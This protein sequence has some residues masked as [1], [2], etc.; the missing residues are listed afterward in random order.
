MHQ[1]AAV[2]LASFFA[3][4]SH[5]SRDQQ[6]PHTS[7]APTTFCHLFSHSHSHGPFG[8]QLIMYWFIE[9]RYYQSI[10]PARFSWYIWYDLLISIHIWW[11]PTQSLEPW[12]SVVTW[13][14]WWHLDYISSPG[15]PGGS[16]ASG[17]QIWNSGWRFNRPWAAG[18][19]GA[20][21]EL[22]PHI[23][24]KTGYP[25]IP[26]LITILPKWQ[27]LRIG[28]YMEILHFQTPA[29]FFPRIAGN[30]CKQGTQSL[31]LLKGSSVW[32]D[33]HRF[34]LFYRVWL[35][36]I[37]TI[38]LN[39]ANGNPA[40][41]HLT[42]SPVNHFWRIFGDEKLLQNRQSSDRV[43]SGNSHISWQVS[44]DSLIASGKM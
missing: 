40:E 44:V 27:R 34:L 7:P 6:D 38:C 12:A 3:F 17:V 24:L 41:R 15:L 2:P 1:S 39:P 23:R 25:K 35:P 4:F 28:K 5:V 18:T 29:W 33:G 43:L 14:T 8:P 11:C 13:F 21:L 10:E 31:L 32:Q 30:M 22:Q 9:V 36:A 26:W 37:F 16:S 20:H 19:G 42:L